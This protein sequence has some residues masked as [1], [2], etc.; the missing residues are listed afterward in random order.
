VCCLFAEYAVYHSL[1]DDFVWMEK[2]GDP[3]FRRHVAGTP[4]W[5]YL[6]LCIFVMAAVSV[7]GGSMMA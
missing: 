4:V 7:L 1:Y 6:T 2:F 3:L 5:L